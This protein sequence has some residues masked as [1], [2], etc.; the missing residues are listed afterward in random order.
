MPTP[1]PFRT[2]SRPVWTTQLA[3][4]IPREEKTRLEQLA[5][6]R[7]RSVSDLLRDAIQSLLN[8]EGEEEAIKIDLS[9]AKSLRC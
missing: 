6:K 1:Q 5:R 8:A 7:G 4:R 9:L 3:C 2:K